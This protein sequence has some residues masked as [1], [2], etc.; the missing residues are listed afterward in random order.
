MIIAISSLK[1]YY[2]IVTKTP[3]SFSV[4]SYFILGRLVFIYCSS[5][6]CIIST[7][8]PASGLKNKHLQTIYS[9]IFSKE[10]P[11]DF[12]IEHFTLSDKDFLEVYW[13][14]AKATDKKNILVVLFHGLA[15]NYKSPYIRGNIQALNDAGFDTVIM[16][17]RGCAEQ[18]NLLPRSYHSGE[19]GDAKEFLNHLRKTTNYSKIF[20]MGFSLGANMLLKL[21]GE[22]QE[23][24]LI[25]GAVAISAP[26][27][28]DICANEIDQGISKYYQYRLVKEL[29]KALDAKYDMH[30]MEALIGLKREQIQD[31]KTF[32]EF[33]DAYT[34][35][36]HGFKSA[37]DYYTKCSSR[38]FLSK[39]QTPTLI[40][41]AKDDPF[42]S[43]SVIPSQGE[44]SDYVTLDIQK[45]GG[46]VGFVEGSFLKPHYWLE[47]RVVEYF[48]SLLYSQ[49]QTH[50]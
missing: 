19:T 12:K 13:H 3:K 4:L 35:P 25:D 29:N 45:N 36:V 34:A 31:I 28:L 6:G 38:Q 17:F 5:K 2:L 48:R 24:N 15:G 43:P 40:I 21:L 1:K 7:F 37:Q 30:D 18:A 26:M 20:C 16:H 39:I 47:R 41:H 44:V 22:L 42:M 46:H 50:S 10:I 33:D 14:K 32:W 11:L 23:N 49:S 9:T 8:K 27:Q